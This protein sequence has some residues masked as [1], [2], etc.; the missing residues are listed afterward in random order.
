M[1][2]TLYPLSVL[3]AGVL[4]GFSGLFVRFLTADGL[5]T[6]EVVFLRLTVTALVAVI[7]FLIFKRDA[8]KIKLK[9][10]WC[11]IGCGCMGLLGVSLCYFTTINMSSLSTACILMYT[12]PIFVT[13][14]SCLF[15][16]ERLSL[17]KIICLIVTFMGCVLC[18]YEQGGKALSFPVLLVGLGSGVCYASY[19]IF[20]RFALNRGVNTPTILLYTFIFAAAGSFAFLPYEHFFAAAA[21]GNINVLATLGIAVLSTALAYLFYTL[22][23]KGVENGKAAILSCIEIVS[24]AV[25]GVIAFKEY[26]DLLQF[27][28]IIMVIVAV[29]AMN[30]NFKKKDKKNDKA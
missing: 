26:P 18:S 11:V 12:A 21:G 9:N 27:S 20:S 13:L 25:V 15:F 7:F 29:V 3:L 22:G 1:R 6:F 24:A 2:K 14:A 4:W 8:F 19:S 23:L 28:G 30:L 16:K 5:T 17:K 10:L